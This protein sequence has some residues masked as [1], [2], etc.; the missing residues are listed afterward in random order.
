VWIPI[1]AAGSKDSFQWSEAILNAA[2]AA[3]AWV[4]ADSYR[5]TSR[6]AVNNR[7]A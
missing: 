2:L 4:V 1:V 5:G 6:L 3:G 7:S